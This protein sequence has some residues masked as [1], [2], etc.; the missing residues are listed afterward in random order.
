MPILHVSSPFAFRAAELVERRV[1]RPSDVEDENI[2]QPLAHFKVVTPTYTKQRPLVGKVL[3][4][5]KLRH[6]RVSYATTDVEFLSPDFLGLAYVKKR[7]LEMY[8]HIDEIQLKIMSVENEPLVHIGNPGIEMGDNDLLLLKTLVLKGLV[9]FCE[10]DLEMLYPDRQVPEYIPK[11]YKESRL[12]AGSLS[13]LTRKG[14][15]DA[16]YRAE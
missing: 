14:T 5:S 10:D 4:K 11:T 2:Q 3:F 8:R 7:F 1:V 6:V 9:S 16:L 15:S 12:M 13:F